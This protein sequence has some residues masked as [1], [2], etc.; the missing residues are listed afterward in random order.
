MQPHVVAH[1]QRPHFLDHGDCAERIL[2]HSQR[3]RRLG[4]LH[5]LVV[6]EHQRSTLDPM[7]EDENGA[8]VFLAQLQLA[9]RDAKE[10]VALL[11]NSAPRVSD[12]GRARAQLRPNQPAG[13]SLRGFSKIA[14]LLYVKPTAGSR[15]ADYDAA[16]RPCYNLLGQHLGKSHETNPDDV[17]LIEAGFDAGAAPADAVA[18]LR[19]LRGDARVTRRRDC[20]RPRHDCGSAGRRDAGRDGSRCCR[21]DAA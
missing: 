10:S 18:K 19:A 17:K 13:I 3:S 14:A 4:H 12:R 11:E 15:C 7:I 16:L 5:D 8:A 2:E 1:H 6:A 20:A 21:R 9:V